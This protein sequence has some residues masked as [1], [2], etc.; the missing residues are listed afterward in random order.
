VGFVV[1]C[2]R[3][4]RQQAST[5]PAGS[6]VPIGHRWDRA[7]TPQVASVPAKATAE[8]RD[9]GYSFSEHHCT[10]CSGLG[11][12]ATAN[13]LSCAAMTAEPAARNLRDAIGR[14]SAAFSTRA[15][16]QWL[17]RFEKR[18]EWPLAAAALI[19]LA[20][21]SVQVLAHPHF[22]AAMETV[23][24][25]MWGVFI[26]DYLARL[27]LATNRR[28]WFLRHLLDL[29]VVAL[30]LLRPLRL[31][32]L[33]ALIVAFQ[34]AIGG[35]IRGRIVIY[36]ASGAV[37]LIYA[38]S[39]ALLDAERSYPGS[40]IKNFGDAVWCSI[41]TVTTVGYGDVP[42]VSGKGRL[43]AVAVMVGGISLVGLVTATL[44][45]WIVQRVAEEDTA[46]QVATSSQIDALRADV[47]QQMDTL[48]KEMQKLTDAV[49]GAPPLE[50]P[51]G[52]PT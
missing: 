22:Y 26:V 7:L 17:E 48:Q 49:T 15:D 47:Q 28:R 24:N 8:R 33:I 46:Q 3:W 50:E 5:E 44:A 41:E 18:S 36:T 29:A 30:P 16:Q 40:N 12:G 25:V 35:A 42:P 51:I 27:T 34:K 14:C 1:V 31:L 6:V 21:F 39:L 20:A 38:A 4:S 9:S 52:G 43:I 11:G 23:M 37:L 13:E 19:F 45:S 2:D 10:T 32:R